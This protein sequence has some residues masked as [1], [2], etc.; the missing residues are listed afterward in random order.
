MQYPFCTNITHESSIMLCCVCAA[1]TAVNDWMTA[2]FGWES[3][4]LAV[5]FAF[6]LTYYWFYDDIHVSLRFLR[7]NY[8]QSEFF[9]SQNAPKRRVYA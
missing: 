7:D 8:S 4:P 1:F 9:S 6:G 3:W 2:W 5:A